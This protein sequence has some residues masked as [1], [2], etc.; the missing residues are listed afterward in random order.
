MTDAEFWK[1]FSCDHVTTQVRFYVSASNAT[2]YG[3]Q[4]VNCGKWKECKRA[5]LST[6]QIASAELR[7]D[8]LST[9]VRRQYCKAQALAS[10]QR[11]RDHADAWWE[12]YR[13]YLGTDE[14]QEK[15]RQVLTRDKS[16]CQMCYASRAVQVHHL[17]YKHL[18]DEPLTDLV[19]VCIRCHS[20]IHNKG[21]VQ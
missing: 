16:I 3:F 11:A 5:I 18:G 9:A 13:T 21:A 4:C 19:S 10:M 17:S 2:R 8:D 15:R 1:P 12:N 20:Q 6:E 7:D 14:W